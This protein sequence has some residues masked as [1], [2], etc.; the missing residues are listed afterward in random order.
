MDTINLVILAVISLFV[1]FQLSF[2]YKAWRLKGSRISTILR[3]EGI[4]GNYDE[5]LLFFHS[6]HCPPCK[7]MMPDI[8]A[9]MENNSNIIPID[10]G[11]FMNLARRLNIRATPTTLFIK[12]GEV[13]KVLLGRQSRQVIEKLFVSK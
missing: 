5:L 6:D 9:L 8:K 3:E 7:Q 4:S 13:K 11:N 10:T 2:Y 1:L 12:D